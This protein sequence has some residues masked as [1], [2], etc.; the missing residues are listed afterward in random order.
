MRSCPGSTEDPGLQ[1]SVRG[2]CTVSTEIPLRAPYT[3][4]STV[5]S[6]VSWLLSSASWK[7]GSFSSACFLLPSEELCYSPLL[8]L[9]LPLLAPGRATV[10]HTALIPRRGA[11]KDGE[12][13]HQE[14]VPRGEAEALPCKDGSFPS[15]S[16]T[17][18]P[19]TG[20]GTRSQQRSQYSGHFAKTKRKAVFFPHYLIRL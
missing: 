17:A 4:L 13:R 14:L 10:V 3:L 15:C 7:L 8:G 9:P 2:A 16:T 19:Q 5:H 6:R 18:L 1:S 12:S 20:W 11:G